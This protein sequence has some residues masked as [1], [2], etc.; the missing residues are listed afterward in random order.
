MTPT[1][2]LCERLTELGYRAKVGDRFLVV[3]PTD[4]H[5]PRGYWAQNHQDC[6]RW[7][8]QLYRD[9]VPFYLESWDSVTDCARR[10]LDIEPWLGESTSLSVSAREK[11]NKAIT[12][13]P[14]GEKRG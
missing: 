12:P 6:A 7:T 11:K 1:E 5:V 8:A 10:G 2:K 13:T 4:I 14:T 3:A 9:G